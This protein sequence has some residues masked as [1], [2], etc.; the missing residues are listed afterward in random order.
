MVNNS[1]NLI[2]KEERWKYTTMN[3]K[4]PTITGHIKIHKT[5]HPIRPVINWRQAPAFK[6][7]K[8]LNQNLKLLTPL[9][10]AHNIQNTMELINKLKDIQISPQHALASLDIANL[11]TNIPVNETKTIINK[12]M[13]K[14]KINP[15][16]RK[17]L[18]KWFDAVTE[19]NYFTYNNN[20]IIQEDGL[21]MGAP[22]SGL[23]AEFFL[24]H[25]ESTHIPKLT[26]KHKLAGYY[27]YMDDILIIYDTSSSN[28]ID[29]L[30]D[31]NNIPQIC[32]S[33][34]NKKYYNKSTFWTSQSIKPKTNGNSQ[35]TENQPSPT[36]SSC[37]TL[38]T[39]TNTSMPQPATSTIECSPM[40]YKASTS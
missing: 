10:Y 7:A 38:T 19:Q 37:T 21:A 23:L 3:P 17:E 33:Q 14:Q 36:P 22:T 34:Q 9:P 18:L 4:A 32:H 26:I 2:P 1:K 16:T 11:Y 5:G 30:R 20:T 8:A 31:F 39:P 12:A 15:S 24:Q 27:R 25:L 6:L 28:M 40:T 29:I 13:I 35:Y